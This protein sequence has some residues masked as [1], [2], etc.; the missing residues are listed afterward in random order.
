MRNPKWKDSFMMKST[1]RQVSISIWLDCWLD[2]WKMSHELIAIVLQNSNWLS[3]YYFCEGPCVFLAN[4]ILPHPCHG[5][6]WLDEEFISSLF[7]G[8]VL[9][10]FRRSLWFIDSTISETYVLQDS[11]LLPQTGIK[12]CYENYRFLLILQPNSVTRIV[13]TW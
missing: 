2:W 8:N 9:F 12:S 1:Q 6:L 11:L 5:K 3:A 7:W 4:K 13:Q 10:F